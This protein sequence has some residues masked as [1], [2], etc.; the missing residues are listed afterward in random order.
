[1]LLEKEVEE[2]LRHDANGRKISEL[3]RI[4][5]CKTMQITDDE[6]L[7]C[8]YQGIRK[9]I[10]INDERTEV[11]LCWNYQEKHSRQVDCEW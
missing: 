11:Y 5:Y 9:Y 4:P 7:R 6:S 2:C 8:P 1:M 10:F 3:E